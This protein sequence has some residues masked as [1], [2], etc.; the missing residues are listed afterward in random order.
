MNSARSFPPH[1]HTRTH[2]HTHAH[3]HAHTRTQFWLTVLS[4][5]GHVVGLYF[6]HSFIFGCTGSSCC[7]WAFFSCSGEG[8]LFLLVCGA[9]PRAGFSCCGAWAPGLQ[10]LWYEGLAAWWHL[11]GPGIKPV[12]PAL[13]GRLPT[14]GAPGTFW[15]VFSLPTLGTECS[16]RPGYTP[17]QTRCSLQVNG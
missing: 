13:A 15:V 2:T 6:S 9:S 11:P 5:R 8:L 1:T 14:T 4:T 3:T 10:K 17:G 12:S 16:R 7:A